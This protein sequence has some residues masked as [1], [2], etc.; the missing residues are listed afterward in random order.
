[1]PLYDYECGSCQHTFEGLYKFDD[2][3][4]C[5]KCG[6]TTFKLPSASC[7]KIKGF[8]DANGYGMKFIDTPGH[9]KETGENS[10]YS[11]SPTKVSTKAI[12]HHDR[13]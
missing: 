13:A 3:V 5:R 9:N 7:I 6:A 11:F 10:G 2:N 12:D 4:P 8:R 1:M